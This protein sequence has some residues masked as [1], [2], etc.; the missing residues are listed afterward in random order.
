MNASA[1]ELGLTCPPVAS[2]PAKPESNRIAKVIPEE[3]LGYHYPELVDQQKLIDVIRRHMGIMETQLRQM[4]GHGRASIENPYRYFSKAIELVTFLLWE[5]GFPNDIKFA[6]TNVVEA[7]V[8]IESGHTAEWLK[9]KKTGGEAI[10]PAR[11]WCVRA[12]MAVIMEFSKKCIGRSYAAT[13]KMLAKRY[14]KYQPDICREGFCIDS[15]RKQ[16]RD[17]EMYFKNGPRPD[18]STCT[19]EEQSEAYRYYTYPPFKSNIAR[20]IYQAR[21]ET[22]SEIENEIGECSPLAIEKRL[23]E[24]LDRDM[25]AFFPH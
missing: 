2:L 18:E 7:M 9:P 14:K 5:A 22:I 25:R 15:W 21:H 16:L 20:G 8:D 6:M 13:E 24:D 17:D 11:V 4:G 10:D 23:L 3:A 19:R 1:A 12:Q